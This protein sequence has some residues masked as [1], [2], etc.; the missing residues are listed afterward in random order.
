RRRSARRRGRAAG[1]GHNERMSQLV[2]DNP[3]RHRFEILVDDALAGFVDY[4]QEPGVVTLVHTEVD[5]AFEGSGVGSALARAV[6]D[7]LRE[8]GD[9]VVPQ[10]PFIA[11]WIGRHREYANLVVERP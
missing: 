7:Q 9:R 11:G 4:R 6:L 10:C 1:F 2:E 8:R 3:A 5:P